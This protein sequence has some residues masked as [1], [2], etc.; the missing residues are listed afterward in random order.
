[1]EQKKNCEIKPLLYSHL[2][3]GLQEDGPMLVHVQNTDVG[4][5]GDRK[6]TML[7]MEAESSGENLN[8]TNKWSFRIFVLC[9]TLIKN[10]KL[11]SLQYTK[12]NFG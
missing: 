1:M 5:R 9:Y 2:I 10:H 8:Q 3:Q 6:K 7:N 11:L 4:L 12:Y